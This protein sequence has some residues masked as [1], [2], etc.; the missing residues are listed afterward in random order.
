VTSLGG[1]ISK[2]AKTPSKRNLGDKAR[3]GP[4]HTVVF[5][6]TQYAYCAT[7]APVFAT[8]HAIQL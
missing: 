1:F 5:F 8:Q 4:D 3:D 7:A 2:P 6:V